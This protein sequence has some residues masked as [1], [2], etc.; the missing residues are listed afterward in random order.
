MLTGE[1]FNVTTPDFTVAVVEFDDVVARVTANFYVTGYSRQPG[2]IEFHGD[3][4][5]LYL[6]SW[7]VFDAKLQCAD[8]G[9]RYEP[10]KLVRDPYEGCEWGRGVVDMGQAIAEGRPHRATGA[11]A[12]HVVEIVSAILASARD[13]K[14]VEVTSTFDP[15]APMEWAT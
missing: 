8:W 10:V 7:T 12:A 1:T 3:A 4:G 9:K 6:A 5:S 15:P 11:Q 2:A 14:P 13:E